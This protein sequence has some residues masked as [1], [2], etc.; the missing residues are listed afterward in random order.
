MLSRLSLLIFCLFLTTILVS[1]AY[2]QTTFHVNTSVDAVDANP[3]DGVCDTGTSSCSLRAAIIEANALSIS[4]TI[5]IPADTYVLTITG[6]GE[7]AAATGDLDVA[8]DLTLIGADAATTII[9]ANYIDRVL[10][11]LASTTVTIENVTIQNGQG[12]VQY[13]RGMGILNEGTLTVRDSVFTGHREQNSDGIRVAIGGGIFSYGNL[14][15]ERSRFVA[16]QAIHGAGIAG[17]GDITVVIE[18]SVFSDNYGNQLGGGFYMGG[19]IANTVIVR[20]SA[21]LNNEASLSGGIYLS[22]STATIENN[23]FSGNVG[24]TGAAAAIFA[25]SFTDFRHNTVVNNIASNGT[26]VSVGTTYANAADNYETRWYANILTPNT[27]TYYYIGCNVKTISLGYNI[28]HSTTCNPDDIEIV[29]SG[30]E[31]LN[32][33]GGFTQTY[34]LEST[35]PALNAIPLEACV[36]TEDQRSLPRPNGGRCDIGAYEQDAPTPPIVMSINTNTATDDGILAENEFTPYAIT[37]MLVTLDGAVDNPVG[38]SDVNDV[39]N[40]ANYRLLR[41]GA[42]AAYSTVGCG[43]LA[44][45]DIAV[46]INSITYDEA[47]FTITTNLNGGTALPNSRYRFIVCPGVSRGGLLFDGNQDNVGG[48]AFIRNFEVDTNRQLGPTFTVNINEDTNDGYC[49]L[50]HCSLRDAILAANAETGHNTIILPAGTYPLTIGDIVNPNNSS[51]NDDNLGYVGDLDVRDALTITGAGA[52]VTT[53]DGI[54]RTHY[55][56][57]AVGDFN[58]RIEGVTLTRGYIG[59]VNSNTLITVDRTYIHNN[60]LQGL[61]LG[62]SNENLAKAFYVLNSTLTNNGGGAIEVSAFSAVIVNTTIT[63]N[64]SLDRS[65]SGAIYSYSGVVLR[66]TTIYNNTSYWY[67]GIR[68]SYNVYNSVIYGNHG[69]LHPDCSGRYISR[70]YNYL[71]ESYGCLRSDSIFAPTDIIDGP[72]PLLSPLQLNGGTTPSLSPLTGSPLIGAGNPGMPGVDAFA[73]EPYD[74]NGV[75]RTQYNCDIGAAQAASIPYVQRLSSNIAPYDGSILN[76]EMLDIPITQFLIKFSHSMTE[77]GAASV[78]NANNYLLVRAG[79]DATLQT[80]SCGTVSGDDI[81]VTIDAISYAAI[82]RTVTLDVNGGTVLQPDTYRLFACAALQNTQGVGLDGNSDGTPAPDFAATITMLGAQT[83]STLVVTTTMDA[84]DG[85]CGPL[86]CTLREAVYASNQLPGQQTIELPNSTYQ[87]G[88]PSVEDPVGTTPTGRLVVTDEVTILGTAPA[89]VYNVIDG[90]NINDSI[91][92]VTTGGNLTVQHINLLNANDSAVRNDGIFTLFDAQIEKAETDNAPALHNTGTATLQDSTIYNNKT[93]VGTNPSAIFNDN[94]TLEIQGTVIYS[95][96]GGLGSLTNLGDDA[97]AQVS[98]SHFY[99]NQYNVDGGGAIHNGLNA[100][101]TIT[102]TE[103]AHNRDFM[104]GSAIYVESGAVTINHATL[105]ENMDK[106]STGVPVYML[107]GGTLTISNSIVVNNYIVNFGQAG[108]VCAGSVTSGGGNVFGNISGCDLSGNTTLDLT[109]FNGLAFY[110]APGLSEYYAVSKP[111]PANPAIG[112]GNPV[113][114]EALDIVGNPRTDGLCDSGAYEE[115]F[116]LTI[117][118]IAQGHVALADDGIYE[119]SDDAV[120]ITLSK[121][122]YNP[123]GDTDA[124]DV[125]NPLHYLLVTAGVNGTFDSAVCGTAQGDDLAVTLTSISYSSI[126]PAIVLSFNNGMPLP[127]ANYRLLICDSLHSI[128][129]TALDGDNNDT[130]GGNFALD[131]RVVNRQPGPVYTVNTTADENDGECTIIHCSLREAVIAAN[132]S[133]AANGIIVDIPAGT[134]SITSGGTDDSESLTGDFNILRSMTIR[135]VDSASTIIDGNGISGV[136]Y[137]SGA[138]PIYIRDLTITGGAKPSGGG[139]LVVTNNFGTARVIV[140]DVVIENNTAYT[141]GGI[142]VYA[143]HLELYRT[144][145]RNNSA[146]YAGGGIHVDTSSGRTLTIEDSTIENNSAPT[147]GG[148]YVAMRTTSSYT[149][150]RSLVANNSATDGAGLYLAQTAPG[151]IINTTFS[152][153]QATNNGGAIYHAGS[154]LLTLSWITVTGNLAD[155]DALD[156]GMGHALYRK[157]DTA[158]ALAT[159]FDHSIIAGNGNAGALQCVDASLN[160]S[161]INTAGF[162]VLGDMSGCPVT[163]YVAGDSANDITGQ[164][165]LLLPLADNGGYTRTHA[166]QATSP[167]IDLDTTSCN[168]TDQR[169]V[170]RQIWGG[171]DSGAYEYS[172]LAYNQIA[173]IVTETQWVNGISLAQPLNSNDALTS[174]VYS[175]NMTFSRSMVDFVNSTSAASEIDNPANYRLVASGVNGILETTSCTLQGDDIALPLTLTTTNILNTVNVAVQGNAPLPIGSYRL[176]A[177]ASLTDTYGNALDGNADGTEGDAY[178]ISFSTTYPSLNLVVTSTATTSD[179]VCDSHCTLNEAISH[180]NNNA[181]QGTFH[182]ALPAGVYNVNGL[183]V[184]ANVVIVGDGMDSTFID[185]QNTYNL[186][187]S[188][189]AI[190]LMLQDMTLQNARNSAISMTNSAGSL[191]LERVAVLNNQALRGGGL[192]LTGTDAIINNTLLMG[193]TATGTTSS[194]GGGA[195]YIT[196][197]TLLIE[198]SVLRNNQAIRG[199]ALLINNSSL[200]FPEDYRLNN[201]TITGNTGGSVIF[202]DNG[203]HLT[204]ATIADNSHGFEYYPMN[205]EFPFYVL[206]LNSVLANNGSA[207]CMASVPY[208][209]MIGSYSV[210]DDQSCQITGAGNS[211]GV[212]AELLDIDGSGLTTVFPFS[213][214]SPVRDIVPTNQCAIVTDLRGNPRPTGSGCDAGSYEDP[215]A[216]TPLFSPT[217][218]R[219]ISRTDTQINLA[220]DDSNTSETAYHLERSTDGTNWTE[221]A[222]LAANTTTYVDTTANVCTAVYQY[223]V[224]VYRSS[225]SA[226]SSYSNVIST[227]LLCPLNAPTALTAAQIQRTQITLTWQDTNINETAYYLERSSNGGTSWSTVAVTGANSTSSISTG[228]T[229]NTPYQF[230]VRAYR[231]ADGAFSAHTSPLAVSSAACLQPGPILNVNTTASG[232]DGS[233]DTAHCT[234][235][236][237]ITV[238]TPIVGSTV[239]IP[240]GTYTP[241][242][243]YPDFGLYAAAMYFN[244][245]TLTIEGA[246]RDVTIISAANLPYGVTAR[247]DTN[248]AIQDLSIINA[249]DTNVYIRDSI[250]EL[251]LTDVSIRGAQNRGG[252]LSYGTLTLNRTEVAEN[253]VNSIYGGG[254]FARGSLYMYDSVVRD[255]QIIGGGINQGGGLY[256]RYPD[257]NN[258]TFTLRI[259]RSLITGNTVQNGYGGGIY[260]NGFHR[261]AESVFSIQNTT[262]SGNTADYGGSGIYI[263]TDNPNDLL[264]HVTITANNGEGLAVSTQPESFAFIVRNSIISGNTTDL[265]GLS[266]VLE[267]VNVIGGNA[268]LGGLQD[269]GGYTMTHALLSGSPALNA[270]A[271]VDCTVNEDQRG[272]P[273][274]QGAG[275]DVGAFE[276]AESL[277][278]MPAPSNLTVTATGLSTVQLSW[279]DNAID[280]SRYIVERSADAGATWTEIARIPFNSTA[281]NDSGLVCNVTYQY[282]VS[283]HRIADDSQVSVVA[284]GSSN[285][286]PIPTDPS[287]L[288]LTAEADNHI[289]LDWVDNASDETAYR[290]ERSADGGA[291]WTEIASIAADSETYADNT[292]LCAIEYDYRVQAVITTYGTASAYIQAVL[293]T[294]CPNPSELAIISANSTIALSWTHTMSSEDEYRVER[295]GD[296]GGVWTEIAVLPANTTG[297]VDSPVE[298]ERHYLYKVRAYRSDDNYFTNYTYTV[299]TI[300][301]TCPVPRPPANVTADGTSRNTITVNWQDN[302]LSV[303]T[304]QVERTAIGT[305]NWFT[306]AQFPAGVE[307]FVNNN[308]LCNRSYDYRIRAFRPSDSLYSPYSPLVSAT[309]LACPPLDPPVVPPIDP[310]GRSEVTVNLP[311]ST[312]ITTYFIERSVGGNAMAALSVATPNWLQIAAIPAH[313]TE[314]TDTGLT[315]GTTYSYRLRGYRAE[316]S[317]YSPYSSETTIITAPCPIPVTNT[318]GLYRNGLWQFRD[319]NASGGATVQFYFGPREAGWT[320]L[321]GDWD[322]NGTDG[323]GLYRNGLFILRNTSEQGA[324]EYRF[325]FGPQESGWQP[326]VGDWNGDGTDTIGI[327]RNGQFYL[328]DSN[329]E[330]TADYRFRLGAQEAGWQ[331]IAGDWDASGWHSVGLYRNGMFYLTNSLDGTGLQRPFQFG[332]TQAGWIGITGDWDANGVMSI[333]LYNGSIW[334]LRNTNDTG[335]TDT[336]FNF[337]AAEAGWQPLA[338]YRGGTTALALMAQS[339]MDN[340]VVILTAI[341]STPTPET[342]AVVV[343]PVMTDIPEMTAEVTEITTEITATALPTETLVTQEPTIAPTETTDVSEPTIVPTET[344]LQ[345]EAVPNEP[346]ATAVPEV[347]VEQTPEDVSD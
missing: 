223:R 121:P 7:D 190:H 23:T 330:G 258:N 301:A 272:I 47:T 41:P 257:F 63:G 333:G 192:Y 62:G 181:A 91:F 132:L 315:C 137:A 28:Y 216:A 37:Q 146:E 319:S 155:S 39:T 107:G 129:Q 340:P 58:F 142:A 19:N 251:T 310:P 308:L 210:I 124:N 237:A 259:E 34:A 204:F 89:S 135:G 50:T 325:R 153:N 177:C 104:T 241:Q 178:S 38:D 1:T 345:T 80:A 347:G 246:G 161:I 74:Q 105:L 9:D 141:G 214:T 30:V 40:P 285:P 48:D 148:L 284:S 94:G 35:S 200:S 342:P 276:V 328:R 31:T 215:V 154:N 222:V 234:I 3:G 59:I 171:C 151:S 288:I 175:F 83:G 245:A 269:N 202:F 139:G 242:M 271:A 238:A 22:Y 97:T 193:N 208:D 341:V 108:R 307:T 211:T 283:A 65:S 147:G 82:S 199:S 160:G 69:S 26:S 138:S 320:A 78:T 273:R 230:R 169:G 293:T 42:D 295:S 292:V 103:F 25:S 158:L 186:F 279:T 240:A 10:H 176:F 84:F 157:Y 32:D 54:D 218:L 291:T 226:Y 164:D 296:N 44:G 102:N 86:H 21:F 128:G 17:E 46:A 339:A 253:T 228:L 60:W 197:G 29:D 294:T 312:D 167:A 156:G 6:I 232:N 119:A 71:G 247:A 264:E 217:N 262:V 207:N 302:N 149:I 101:L 244:N 4:A 281:Y 317:S 298:C 306:I 66:N 187:S 201:T 118:G 133:T 120:Q 255:N 166:M 299:N 318:V 235:E 194:S 11:T 51:T 196:D 316:D 203:F 206:I 263:S 53:I 275:C 33:N 327:Y 81:P 112:N 227:S 256:I 213:L 280:E 79:A 95:N 49:S 36:L 131:F 311:A 67:G 267:G 270:I 27:D 323:I 346:V 170:H 145:I 70:G 212:D 87:L 337:G 304:Y 162:N 243:E 185:G 16:N 110:D 174:A 73:C 233:C 163:E 126:P 72:D 14:T 96:H 109:G 45:D 93:T 144:V 55:L 180:A 289:R 239:R 338:S 277:A 43:A 56:L 99:A 248:V 198:D 314:F 173:P 122:A 326:I 287:N 179:S 344:A 188:N 75:A 15:V 336:G 324:V 209:A 5:Y 265:A 220:W 116:L 172:S 331:A 20:R 191:T 2:A 297:Y 165:P 343:T 136:F 76:N 189:Q 322:G 254:I 225:D 249:R 113:Y 130:A 117:T 329:S 140:S 309:T 24:R 18:D 290:I 111:A 195:I 205:G 335:S 321:T 278:S 274:P 219:L 90:N 250:A 184:R 115:A 305:G 229:C 334:R 12:Q 266:P 52:D 100:S 261:P 182:I 332:P 252:I 150:R 64:G 183:S 8:T 303:V 57:H 127:E 260:Y 300:T 85:I 282:R 268:L 88:L 114:C 106:Q 221:I 286:C 224:R 125:T 168:M 134:Y 159:R 152:N 77:S 68:G 231:I 143:S 236:E 61:V 98:Q 123:V 92:E 313:I 13:T